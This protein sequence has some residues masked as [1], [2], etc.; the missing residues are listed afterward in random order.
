M[1]QYMEISPGV[2][3]VSY[4]EVMFN[5]IYEHLYGGLHVR[6]YFTVIVAF[7]RSSLCER[8]YLIQSIDP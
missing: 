4:L 5:D 2:C 7:I 6:I 1:L 3:R 8:G